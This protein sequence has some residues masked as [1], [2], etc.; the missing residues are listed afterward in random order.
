MNK[1]TNQSIDLLKAVSC[2]AVVFMHC[3]FPGAFG[4]LIAYVLRFPVPVFFMISGYYSYQKSLDWVKKKALYILKLLIASEFVYCIFNIMLILIQGQAVSDYLHGM[5][6]SKNIVECIFC[7]ALFCGPLWYLYSMFW[8]WVIIYII[9]RMKGGKVLSPKAFYVIPILLLIAIVG[10]KLWSNDDNIWLYRNA[11]LYGLPFTLL[12]SCLKSIEE[13]AKISFTMS[14]ILIGVGYVLIVG[15]YLMEPVIHDFQL[16]TVFISVGLF[17]LAVNHEKIPFSCKWLLKIG[18]ELS[19]W[20]YI[21]HVAFR[22]IIDAIGAAY[23]IDQ[24]GT[25]LWMRPIVI[26]CLTICFSYMMARVTQKDKEVNR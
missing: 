9:R 7:G 14:M 25:F 8:T 26:L 2:I 11:L 24:S 10:R 20:I 23:R 13:K 1:R 3:R 12:G 17:T 16:S 21:S 6:A 18:S 4:S 5:F 15:E 22:S 19:L